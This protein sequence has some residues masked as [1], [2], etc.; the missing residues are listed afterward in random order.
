MRTPARVRRSL[1]A[2]VLA[3][4]CSLA[5]ATSPARAADAP[6]LVIVGTGDSEELLRI[7]AARYMREFP[8]TRIEVPDSIGTSGGIKAAL[9]DGCRKRYGE[10]DRKYRECINGDRHSEDALIEGCYARYNGN[11]DKLRDCLRA[12]R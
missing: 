10:N 9:K 1:F 12:A 5:C 8:E 7:L 3:A 6:P 11:K 4:F 2:A